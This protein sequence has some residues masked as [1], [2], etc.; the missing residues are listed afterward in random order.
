MFQRRITTHLLEQNWFAVGIDFLIVVIGVFV[1]IQVSNWNDARI[2]R[3]IGENYLNGFR[4]DLIIDRQ[5]LESELQARQTQRDDVRTIL[6]FYDGRSLDTDT[7]FTAYYAALY[8]RK[9]RPNR[10]TIDEVLN[11]AGLRLIENAELRSRLLD[12]YAHYSV[13]EDAETHIARDFDTYLYD[14]TFS[15]IPIQISGPWEDTQENRASAEAL[16]AD[17]TIANGFRLVEANLTLG[18]EGL[19]R[20]LESALDLVNEILVKLK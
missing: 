20:S 1:G 17:V 13:I 11:S 6:G 19:L 15:K 12:L 3:Q 9:I 18:D 4:Q 16:L 10:N 5:M 7:F 8:S 2:D 14:T